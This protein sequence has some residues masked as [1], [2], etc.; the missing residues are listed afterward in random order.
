MFLLNKPANF[1]VDVERV[2]IL[3]GIRDFFKSLIN[4]VK[5]KISLYVIYKVQV[6]Y[7]KINVDSPM[8]I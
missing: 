1:A 2:Y 3:Y 4:Q 7:I 6:K 5:S 8:D